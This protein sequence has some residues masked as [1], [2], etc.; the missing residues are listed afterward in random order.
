MPI[1]G[2]DFLNSYGSTAVGPF[3]GEA[4]PSRSQ[5]G[6]LL[7]LS[8]H[9]SKDIHRKAFISINNRK[10][11]FFISLTRNKDNKKPGSQ[12]YSVN[13]QAGSKIAP[14]AVL[15]GGAQAESS[16]VRENKKG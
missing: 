5:G 2:S 14:L 6:H 13:Q 16:R 8:V 11:T 3:V 9:F 7:G 12:T 10:F 15:K 1:P 4:N